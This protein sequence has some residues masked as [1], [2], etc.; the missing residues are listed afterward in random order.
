MG[1]LSKHIEKK[2]DNWSVGSR[3]KLKASI[4]H[5]MNRIF[6]GILNLLDEEKEYGNISDKVHSGLRSK[7][8]NIG[9][10]QV[11][12][13]KKELDDRYNVEFIPYNIVLPV[14][15]IGENPSLVEG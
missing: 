8:L 13:M 10:D 2:E 6:V 1:R 7:I 12:N 11:R 15:P 4:G 3:K 14:K 5:K 9:N